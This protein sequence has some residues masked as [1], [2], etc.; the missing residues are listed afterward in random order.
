MCED[1]SPS[2]LHG[3]SQCSYA[4]P[5]LSAQCSFLA[6]HGSIESW[7]LPDTLCSFSHCKFEQS[8]AGCLTCW[9]A[10]NDSSSCL[11]R[12]ASGSWV[13]FSC[14]VPVVSFSVYWTTEYSFCCFCLMLNFNS[15]LCFGPII[16]C[17]DRSYCIHLLYEHSPFQA[18]HCH[19]SLCLKM[20]RI[21]RDSLRTVAG[22]S[23]TDG[24]RKLLFL[25]LVELFHIS[26]S[27][28]IMASFS[29]SL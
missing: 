26:L 11:L 10:A 23:S 21:V 24:E 27:D 20:C 16:S 4:G 6:R 1:W 2:W 18:N 15:C 22:G 28:R 13:S 17:S 7:L 19:E 3:L 29:S 14:L 12:C 25:T 5:C 9:A 8:V